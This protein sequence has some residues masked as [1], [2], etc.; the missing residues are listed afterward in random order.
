[1]NGQAPEVFFILSLFF[2]FFF[3]TDD[4]VDG[5]WLA[6]ADSRFAGK[7]LECGVS[8]RKKA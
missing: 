7:T 2:F 3:S 6:V 8:V 4:E 1:M 5:E